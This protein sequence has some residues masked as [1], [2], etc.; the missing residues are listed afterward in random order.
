MTPVDASL[1]DPGSLATAERTAAQ[2]DLVFDVGLHQGEDAAFYLRKGFRV[3]GFEADPALAA[4]CRARFAREIADGRFRIVEGAIAPASAGD[5]VTFHRSS[6][7]VWGTVDP[8]WVERNREAGARSEAIVLPRVDM[9]EAF[10]AFGVPHYLKIDV[11]GVDAVALEAL[12]RQPARPAYVSIEST[13]RS[14]D[15]LVAEFDLFERLGYGS[16]QLVQQES[17]PGTRLRTTDRGGQPLA[18]EF[19]DHASGP[20]GAD[21]PGPWRGRAEALRLY[22]R[23]FASYALFGRNAPLRQLLGA[24]ALRVL[25]RLLRRLLPGWYDTHARLGTG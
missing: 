13:M 8:D 16:F 1:H 19:P 6:L 2:D 24:R 9:D 23:V 10:R 15:D 17:V 22:R 3:V 12:L 14:F 21:L 25:S 5:A 18:Y 11:E 7:S 4:H 20:F